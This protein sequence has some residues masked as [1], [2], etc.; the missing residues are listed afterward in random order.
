VKVTHATRTVE[1]VV[2]AAAPVERRA[3]RLARLVREVTMQAQ[4]SRHRRE[5]V[6]SDYV[7]SDNILSYRING[8][9]VQL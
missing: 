9:S 8:F 1:R 4:L 7:L 6:N 5:D 2:Q 3:A